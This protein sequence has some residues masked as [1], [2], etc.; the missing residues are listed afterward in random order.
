[1]SAFFSQPLEIVILDSIDYHTA[2]Q[3]HMTQS[4][5]ILQIISNEYYL[6]KTERIIS[7]KNN[8]IGIVARH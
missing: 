6:H 2:Y 4:P 3:T 8:H 5:K 7:I 1:M